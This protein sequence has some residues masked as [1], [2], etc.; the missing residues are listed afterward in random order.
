MRQLHAPAPQLLATI[1]QGAG[2]V[3]DHV[4]GVLV[5]QCRKQFLGQGDVR[6][7]GVH[8][9]IPADFTEAD[10][11]PLASGRRPGVVGK[12]EPVDALG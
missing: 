6:C 8:P 3:V 11:D 5:V 4:T 1:D 7:L 10:L 9:E 12:V 2:Q